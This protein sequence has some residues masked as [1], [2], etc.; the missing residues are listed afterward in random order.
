M[1]KIISL[2]L[3][4]SP[5][6]L[7][8]PLAGQTDGSFKVVVNPS[9]QISEMS[10][11]EVSRLFL[12]KTTRWSSGG[13]VLPVDQLPKSPVRIDFSQAIH[14]KDVDVVKSYW[15]AQIFSGIATPP[16]ELAS[17]AEV[18]SY[19]RSRAGAIGYLSK[20]ASPGDGVKVLKITG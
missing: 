6:A 14:R 2:S 13:Q 18:L 15:Q 7:G 16:P 3:L 11:A 12:K 17:D 1:R 8:L 19:V 4:L 20:E 9:V 5:L 10:S